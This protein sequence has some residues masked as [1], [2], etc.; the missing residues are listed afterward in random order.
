MDYELYINESTDLRKK[1]ATSLQLQESINMFGIVST[2]KDYRMGRSIDPN[3]KCNNIF[4][5]NMISTKEKE[6]N[7]I[8]LINDMSQIYEINGV[9]INEPY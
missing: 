4:E 7:T 8:K 3:Y 2:S 9:L 1:L 6:V 5:K